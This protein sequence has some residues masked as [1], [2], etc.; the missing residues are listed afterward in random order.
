MI[1]QEGSPHK[2]DVC[3]KVFN[4]RSNLKT[5]MRTH[6]DEKPYM[7]K[8]EECGKEF[9]RNCDLRRHNLTHSVEA[10]SAAGQP[11]QGQPPQ[12][13]C[14]DGPPKQDHLAPTNLSLSG[15][16]RRRMFA[17][18]QLSAAPTQ[19]GA[20]QL[21]SASST[22]SCSNS[23]SGSSCASERAPMD[24]EDEEGLLSPLGQPE[25]LDLEGRFR[26]A[27]RDEPLFAGHDD[28]EEEDDED[29]EEI[30]PD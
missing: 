25:R 14:E 24:E 12:Q 3:K 27:G 9:R 10:L 20:E 4:Q 15:K 17:G 5:H 19:Y 6:T 18:G 22:V 8:Y 28:E 26:L 23:S 21:S 29:D 2:C 16:E 30:Y 1:H 7:C 13:Q 11:Q